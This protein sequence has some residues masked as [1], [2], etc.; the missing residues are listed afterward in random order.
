MNRCAAGDFS[1]VVPTSRP[2]T[3]HAL[4]LEEQREVPLRVA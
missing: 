2:S 4:R 1:S 3:A